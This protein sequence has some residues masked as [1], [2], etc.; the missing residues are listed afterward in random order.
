MSADPQLRE[1]LERAAGFLQVDPAVELDRLHGAA[2]RRERGRRLRALAVA[3]VIGVLGIVVAWQ[4]LPPGPAAVPAGIPG[5]RIAFLEVDGRRRVVVGLEL[6]GGDVTAL[7]DQD[8]SALA[9]AWS[10]D[11]TRI[12]TVVER[13]GP[14]YR[15]VVANADGTDPVTIV[16][17]PG[18]GAVGPDIIDVA[19]S[20]DGAK[21][22]YAGRVVEDGVARRTILIEDADGTGAPQ[23]LEGHWESVS[24]SPDGER[25][26]V[27]GF[28]GREAPF[29]LF[30]VRPD[31]S[32]LVRLTNDGA[33]LHRAL[34]SP[35]GDRI[36]SF[37][38][39]GDYALDVYVMDADG[40]N[41]RRLTSWE[42]LDMFPVWSP[43]GEWI[44][45]ASDRDATPA[46]Q[47][48]NRSGEG[49]FTGL[50]TYAMRADGS[51]LREVLESD[52][53]LPVSWTS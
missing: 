11:G 12:A 26:L 25:L 7:S 49:I 32:G 48:S 45:F 42:G 39:D 30:T 44:A 31:G 13:P 22:A 5:G 23:A 6:E 47:A 43:D 37:S 10:P 24:W 20:P 14:V 15:V 46:Q 16:Q 41:R 51:G 1:R 21:I 28:P 9:A 8:A 34:W 19:W 38:G 35:T 40:A 2:H 4:L 3:A 18:T 29:D 17:E 27:S 50:S 33:A 52:G 36:V 53:A